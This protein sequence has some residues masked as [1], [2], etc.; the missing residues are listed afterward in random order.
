MTQYNKQA[1][2]PSVH[3]TSN[4]SHVFLRCLHV[5]TN[6]IN[7]LKT[8][9]KALINSQQLLSSSAFPQQRIRTVLLSS[10]CV[11]VCVGG[12]VESAKFFDVKN[13]PSHSKRLG[14]TGPERYH[15]TNCSPPHLDHNTKIWYQSHSADT[16]AVSRNYCIC[17]SNAQ[18]WHLYSLHHSQLRLNW[19]HLWHGQTHSNRHIS[20]E[21]YHHY[22]LHH[23]L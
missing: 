14:V 9:L 21:R 7:K 17:Y 10:V 2:I 12:G 20:H 16:Q 4:V 23:K 3:W 15:H 5:D 19:N 1:N 11:C 8:N 13:G 22:S 18:N 6:V